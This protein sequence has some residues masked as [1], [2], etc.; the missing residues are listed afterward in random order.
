M[1]PFF[2]FML[3][4]VV[5]LFPIVD[6]IGGVPIFL[7]LTSNANPRLR[8][9]ISQKI[10]LYVVLILIT[11]LL[12]GGVILR[13]FGISLEV[14][15]IAGGIVIFH[16]GWRSMESQPKLTK[17]DNQ[18]ATQKNNK[19]EDISLMPMAI[20][21]LAGPGA[22]AIVLG[23][24]AQAGR[25]YTVETALNFLAVSLAILLIGGIV[26][27]CLR[28]ANFL[29][30]W[31]GETGIRAI[32]RILGLFILAIGVQFFLNGISD[33]MAGLEVLE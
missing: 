4:S 3:G 23:L 24:S 31:L 28:S 17:E 5:A 25:S 7:A 22:I 26:Y 19:Q 2:E 8:N 9:K 16:A 32:T 29:L 14:V 10:A 27:L 1:Q 20:P 11:F 33:W 18:A 15:R 13:F 6:P 12:F 30:V 21:M